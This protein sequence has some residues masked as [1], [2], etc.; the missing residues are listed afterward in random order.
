MKR[1]FCL[2]LCIIM[3]ASLAVSVFAKDDAAVNYQ[4]GLRASAPKKGDSYSE[5]ETV[6]IT[7][8]VRDILESAPDIYGIGGTLNY[9]AYLLTFKSVSFATGFSGGSHNNNTVEGTV[10]LSFLCSTKNGE[11]A[12]K[13]VSAEFDF[14][15][16]SF[17]AK[18]SGTA[19]TFL[20]DFIITNKDATERLISSSD[21]GV[22]IKIGDGETVV[23]KELLENVIA[24]AKKNLAKAHVGTAEKLT[25]PA[26]AVSQQAFDAYSEA[27]GNAENALDSATKTSEIEAAIRALSTASEAFEDA[28]VFGKRT[29]G[30]VAP[31]TSKDDSDDLIEVVAT[32]NPNGKLQAGSEK[33]LARKGTSVSIIA[34]PDEGFEV[35]KFVINGVEYV[36]SS[37]VYTIES[38]TH[39]TKVEVFFVKK[40]RFT[41]V[42]RGTWFFDSV[43]K[44]AEI[45]LFAGTSE[46]KFS[47]DAEM[48]RAMLVT[49]LHRLDGT[50]KVENAATFRDV[51]AGQWYSDAVAWASESGL[52]KGYTENTFGTDDSITR[53]DMVTILYRYLQYKGMTPDG[54]KE[55]ADFTDAGEVSAYALD[56][57]KWS[58]G[59][60]LV[61][62]TSERA[63]SPRANTT[64]AQVATI[65]LRYIENISE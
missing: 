29:G 18:K 36:T 65:I 46:T 50:P 15:T 49:V 58:Y 42:P 56:A 10:S 28:K 41:D 45:G 4:L 38:V 39:A 62:G 19:R 24:D 13:K 37:N 34:V 52:V 60:G 17:T 59:T 8:S 2:L 61:K 11:L 26:F 6:K 63:L 40:P 55:I 25:Y 35:E 21:A 44:I 57:V 12:G 5:G 1:V 3:L 43:E 30:T 64:R 27:I 47:P 31:G 20:S 51:A 23:S 9:D 32:A 33:Q 14:C 22:D 54:A 7:V 16:I 48:T 53:Q